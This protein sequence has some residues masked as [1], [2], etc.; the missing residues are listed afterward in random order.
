[1][2]AA[3]QTGNSNRWAATSLCLSGAFLREYN[4]AVL[5]SFRKYL[6]ICPKLAAFRLKVVKHFLSEGLGSVIKQG[7][8]HAEQILIIEF[9]HLLDSLLNGINKN[10]SNHIGNAYDPGNP[11]HLS[12][13]T[14]TP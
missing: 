1:V 13:L 4:R 2:T 6:D 9:S 8:S 11:N 3:S 10:R 12:T 5:F 7:Q 14:T